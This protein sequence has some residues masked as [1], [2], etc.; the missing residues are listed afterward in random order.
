M[1]TSIE[2]EVAPATVPAS[3][4]TGNGDFV[5]VCLRGDFP[6]ALCGA[7]VKQESFDEVPATRGRERCPKCLHEA[8]K[9]LGEG[10]AH[11]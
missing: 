3:G 1:T 10:R 11:W 8:A 7:I 5:H 4:Q 2:T 9:L 6:R